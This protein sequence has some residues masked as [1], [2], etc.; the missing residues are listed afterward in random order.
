MEMQ[1]S[2]SAVLADLTQASVCITEFC[3]CVCYSCPTIA[4]TKCY[5]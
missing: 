3:V 1:V 5:V 2:V 4:C